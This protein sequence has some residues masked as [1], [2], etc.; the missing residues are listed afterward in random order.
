MTFWDLSWIGSTFAPLMTGVVL[1]ST[2][3]ALLC[4]VLDYLLRKR[5]AEI[6]H[7]VWHGML[8]ALLIFP[9]LLVLVPPLKHSSPALRRAESAI[10]PGVPTSPTVVIVRPAN[11]VAVIATPPNPFPW[12]LVILAVY[13][14]VAF[15]LALRLALSLRQIRGI[16]RRSEPLSDT[17]PRELAQEA[18]LESG[19]FIKPYV[20]VS[21]DIAVPVALQS[22]TNVFVLLPDAWETW[23]INKLRLVL[24]HEMAHVKR[25]DPGTMLLASLASCIYWFHPL[26]WLIKR[27]LTTLSEYA[28]DEHA[29]TCA[30]NAQQYVNA[31]TD[32][33]Q[34]VAVYRGRVLNPASAVVHRSELESRVRRIFSASEIRRNGLSIVRCAMLATLIPMVYVAAAARP[35]TQE[36][37]S[38]SSPLQNQPWVFP[39]NADEAAQMEAQLASNPDDTNLHRKMLMYYMTQQQVANF[40]AQLLWFIQHDPGAQAVQYAGLYPEGTLLNT[41]DDYVRL[42]AAWEQALKRHSDSPDVLYNGATF[43]QHTDPERSITLLRQAVQLDSSTKAPR[44]EA[45]M[46]NIYAQ[47]VVAALHFPTNSMKFNPDLAAKLQIELE[48]SIDPALLSMT[49]TDLVRFAVSQHDNP[50]LNQEGFSLLQRAIDLDPTNA[51]WKDA[52]ESAKYESVRQQNYSTMVQPGS[53]SNAQRIGAAVMEANLVTKVDP[54]YPPLALSARIQGTVAF[55]ITV[56]PDGHVQN[57]Q[58]VRGHP[59]LVNAAK[60]AVLQYVYRPTLLNGKPVTVVTDVDIPFKLP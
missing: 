48:A 15:V 12:S 60:D 13:I 53:A 24:A 20:R 35:Y 42:A 58:L 17:G 59:L 1:R 51:K 39:A 30:S 37:Q 32:F 45:Q 33:A 52:L 9:L 4:G 25:N 3:L 34:E 57:V 11:K 23:P 43:F 16:V 7:A 50:V 49:G 21:S 26:S 40:V 14:A 19:A 18:W 6:R 27:R 10:S 44:Y 38:G 29:L 46:A 55:T 41:P 36:A 8:V 2:V 47:A 56:G 5:P 31:L 28:C 22:D 54:V